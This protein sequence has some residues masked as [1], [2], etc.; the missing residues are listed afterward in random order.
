MLINLL[1]YLLFNLISALLGIFTEPT[2]TFLASLTILLS[3]RVP[4][5]DLELTFAISPKLNGPDS[6]LRKLKRIGKTPFTVFFI[7]E[8]RRYCADSEETT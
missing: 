4:S 5:L 3:T 2:P 6:F 1:T 7:F 8:A